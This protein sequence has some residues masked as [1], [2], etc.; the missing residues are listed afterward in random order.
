MRVKILCV[1]ARAPGG[2]SVDHEV[3]CTHTHSNTKHART[4]ARTH[5]HVCTSAR[6]HTQTHTHSLTTYTPAESYLRHVREAR[7]GFLRSS[8]PDTRG[9]HATTPP[10][11]SSSPPSSDHGASLS[12]NRCNGTWHVAGSTQRARTH[13]SLSRPPRTQV[14]SINAALVSLTREAAAGG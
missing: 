13:S 2:D 1:G 7:G 6:A 9:A 14:R 8:Q 3:T 11:N 12:C 5:A 10:I 4:H